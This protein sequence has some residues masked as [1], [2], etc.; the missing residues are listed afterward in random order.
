MN[1]DPILTEW[2]YR[3]PKGYPTTD[4]DYT[5]L[6]DVLSEM[7]T[8]SHNDRN[9][10]VNQAKGLAPIITESD[11]L[12]NLAVVTN[13]SILRSAIDRWNEQHSN[14]TNTT[15]NVKEYDHD[16]K[17]DL[18]EFLTKLP[19]EADDIVNNLLNNLNY[20]EA[21]EFV[22][23]LYSYS[24]ISEDTLNT[25]NFRSGFLNEIFRLEPKGIGKGEILLA[26]LFKNSKINGAG[27][28]Y[29]M[30][31]NG[32]PYEIKD[33]TG[34]TSKFPSIRLGTKGSV[35]NFGFWDEITTTLKRI[36]QLRGTIENPKFDFHKIFHPELLQAIDYL[37]KRKSFILAGNLNFKDNAM[38]QTFYREAN[39][40]NSDVEG[41]TNVILRGPNATPVELS[42]EPIATNSDG[43]ITIK[44]IDNDSQSLTYVN[45]ELRRLKYV[46]EPNLLNID[47]Q[48]AVD[49]ITK[50]DLQFIVFRKDRVR[51]T[52]EFRFVVCDAGR[53]RIVEKS[54]G[55]ED[56]DL[57]EEIN[58]EDEW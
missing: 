4:S 9:R 26:I 53:I 40:I 13:N 1:I 58:E 34:G 32:K 17:E 28:T 44:P 21:D 7:T 5:I 33:Y 10:I 25:I 41:F 27:A 19:V 3:L 2:Q 52:N 38:L 30:D 51:L 29:D 43:S 45:T 39:T 24:D 37:D 35:T 47:L 55:A 16:R 18:R 11:K 22:N 6:Y 36:D 49:S 23:M 48:E 8:F 15:F 20:D 12:S 56:S 57:T 50:G 54:I 31:Q 46:R 42:I 14:V